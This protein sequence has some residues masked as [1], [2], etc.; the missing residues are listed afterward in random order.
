M[1]DRGMILVVYTVIGGCGSV[2]G[3][4]VGLIVGRWMS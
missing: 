1:T 2:L 4:V 3:F